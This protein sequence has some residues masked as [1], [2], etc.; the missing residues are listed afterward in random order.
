MAKLVPGA[1]AELADRQWRDYRA[2]EPGTCFA[3]LN[4]VLDLPQAYEL[5]RAVSAL[6]VA[7]GDRVIGYKIGCTGAGTTSQFGIEGPVRGYLY[8][9]EVHQTGDRLD[10]AAFARLAIEGEM[11]LR[12]GDDGQIAATFP[13]IE[14]H[15]FVFRTP[16]KTLVELVAN[17]GLNAGVV[18]PDEAWL[19]S[20]T[21]LAKQAMLSVRINGSVV[22]SGELWPLPGGPAESLS[23]L[24]HHLVEFGLALSPSQI[25]LAGTPL[26]LYPVQSGD[27]IVVFIDDEPVTECFVVQ[28]IKGGACYLP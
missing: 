6:R 14:L 23:W 15:H 4:F 25:V 28:S 3:E 2:R 11:A 17:N 21:Y 10:M 19:S 12:I 22:G 24:K 20:R 27:H 1:L 18:L 13:V 5:Q 16:R 8:E 26:G 9:S 7:A